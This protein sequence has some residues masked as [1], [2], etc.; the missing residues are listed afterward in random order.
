M[1]LIAI[2]LP[3]RSV[4][5]ELCKWQAVHHPIIFEV[6]R[7]DALVSM[8]FV[9]N[10][11]VRLAMGTAGA[12]AS[13][14]VGDNIKYFSPSG[15]FYTWEVTE[16]LGGIIVTDG[17]ITG[18]EWGGF[19]NYVDSFKNY[20]VEAEIFSIDLSNTY[21]SIGTLRVKPNLNDVMKLSV[22][23]WIKSSAEFQN[24]FDY[25]QINEAI[26]GEGGRFSIRWREFYTGSNSPLQNITGISYWTNSAKQIQE[27]YGSNMGDFC[28]TPDATR[29]SNGDAAKFM[30]VFSKPT[31]FVGFPFSLNFIYSDNLT[32]LVITRKEETF[33]VNDASVSTSSTNLQTSERYHNNRLMLEQGYT[34]DI[35]ELDVWLEAGIA[36]TEPAVGVPS[37]GDG[38]IFEPYSPTPPPIKTPRKIH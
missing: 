17:T 37:Y 27:V 5:G 12:S 4:N 29:T 13:L 7:R 1:S 2:T 23:E 19:I 15:A 20:Y 11:F 33:D 22:N 28:P 16:I 8:K 36:T 18:S 14:V 6:Q 32:N 10:G 34:S 25:T 26:A 38:T 21:V 35:K 30:S 3:E 9:A 31:Y 24:D